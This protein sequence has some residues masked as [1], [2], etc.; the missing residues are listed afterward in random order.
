MSQ[1]RPDELPAGGEQRYVRATLAVT[2]LELP[3]D[4]AAPAELVVMPWGVVDLR[5]AAIR[6]AFDEPG[7]L[8]VNERS[9]EE[10]PANYAN[11]D[12]DAFVNL[13]HNRWGGAVGWITSATAEPDRGVVV[14][15][16]WTP[17]GEQLIQD[18]EYRYTSLECILDASPWL[19]N[20]DPAPVVA[21]TGLGLVNYPAVISQPPVLY[22]SL[23]AALSAAGGPRVDGDGSMPPVEPGRR[24]EAAM[25]GNFWQKLVS[26]M[27]GRESIDEAEAALSVAEVQ[28]KLR[29]IDTLTTQVEELSTQLT[30]VTADRDAARAELAEMQAGAVRSEAERAVEAALSEGRISPAMREQAL[31]QAEVNLEAFTALTALTP[32]GTFSAP[33]GRQVSDAAIASADAT[34]DRTAE[35]AEI[36]AYAAQHNVP[37]HTAALAIRKQ[38][39]GV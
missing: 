12:V 18:R 16:D 23:T 28:T 36:R 34:G 22:D 10:I 39:K 35:D 37:Y 27:T 1:N 9:A 2:E 14:G 20:G 15:V 4:G 17:R 11:R 32:E 21:V 25:D 7:Q 8:L 24:G 19:A 38:R 31:E 3:E 33:T 13:E 29:Q 6:E 26:R 30:T 5:D